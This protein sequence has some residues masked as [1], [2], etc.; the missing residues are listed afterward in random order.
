MFLREWFRPPRHLLALF[1]AIIVLPAAVLAWL[2]WRTFEQDRALERQRLRERVETAAASVV[3]GLE[4]RLDELARQLPELAAS[5]DVSLPDDSVLLVTRS[6]EIVER[7]SGRLLYFPRIPKASR[8]R[9]ARLT[10][11]ETLE[12]RSQNPASAAEAFR[13]VARDQDPAVRAAALLGLARCLRKIGRDQEALVAYDDLARLGAFLVEDAPA[14]L[15]ARHARC[16]L[17]AERKTPGL[18]QEATVLLADL[19]GRRW[20]LDRASHA[21]YS[22]EASAWLPSPSATSPASVIVALAE[23]AGEVDRLR[24]RLGTQPGRGRTSIRFRDSPLVFVWENTPKEMTALVRGPS[25]FREAAAPWFPMGVGI[26]LVDR[27]SRAVFGEP[28]ALR[29][30]VVVRSAAD[31]GLPW[32]LRVASA[33]PDR[34]LASL[35]GRRKMTLAGLALLGVLVLA[36]GYLVERAVARELAAARLQADFVATVSHE[37]RS[38]LTSM[39]HLLEM[40]EDGA[41]PSEERRQRYYKV[42]SGEA[43]RLRQLVEH[44]LDFRRMEEGK[45]EYRF[46]PLDVSELVGQ[47]AGEF[48]SQPPSRERLL[49]TLDGRNPVVKGDREALARALRNLLDNAAKYSPEA[50]PIH[51]GLAVDERHVSISVRDHGPGIPPNEQKAVFRRFFRGAGAARSGVKGT[52]IGLATVSHIVRAHRG[53]IRLDTAPGVGS[54]FT[55]VLPSVPEPPGSPKPVG[56]GG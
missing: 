33:D 5:A 50:A 18:A 49:V 46:E 25:W 12:Y 34:E 28:G 21:F 26:A 6:D 23:A 13:A 43:E 11:A 24:Q 3:S 55:I 47:I 39:K 52:G 38:P 31:T 19:A 32:T 45:V 36:G 17:L 1:I 41:V 22:G 44:L 37:F 51:V 54:T 56:E 53:E 42:L 29:S 7:P 4:S 30:P 16:A 8:P 35:S 48:G 14:E 40:L 2:A 15:V 20:I 10:A 27:E 9:D